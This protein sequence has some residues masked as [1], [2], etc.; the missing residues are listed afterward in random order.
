M[1]TLLPVRTQGISNMRRPS[2]QTEIEVTVG[3]GAC[4]SVMSVGICEK[5]DVIETELSRN[6]AEYEV[7][8]GRP[9]QTS[10]RGS[11]RS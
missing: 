10:E 7:A 6:G 4:V 5:I 11:A 9:S 2:E 3:Y 1:S 8:I